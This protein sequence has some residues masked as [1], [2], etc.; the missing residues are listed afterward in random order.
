MILMMIIS[1]REYEDNLKVIEANDIEYDLA[2]L[3]SESERE[4]IE[5]RKK[6]RV[7]SIKD[8]TDIDITTAAEF[9]SS[10]LLLKNP[11][12]IAF[13]DSFEFLNKE[14]CHKRDKSFGSE[15]NRGISTS[16]S[17]NNSNNYSSSSSSSSSNNSND[18]SS[19]NK[20]VIK[21]CFRDICQFLC[22]Y[23]QSLSLRAIIVHILMLEKDS[24]KFHQSNCLS[25]LHYN[26]L[27]K[28]HEYIIDSY[29][30]DNCNRQDNACWEVF[31]LVLFNKPEFVQF[32]ER[33]SKKFEIALYKMP[34][35][36]CVTPFAFRKA[37]YRLSKLKENNPSASGYLLSGASSRGAN[38]AAVGSNYTIDED[39]IEIIENCG[40]LS[41]SEQ[42]IFDYDTDSNSDFSVEVDDDD[43]LDSD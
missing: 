43:D 20:L 9:D 32:L 34:K 35:D 26:I 42:N 38:L 22:T 16:I 10:Y 24:L 31:C 33:I 40:E 18:N 41:K 5:S 4:V 19:N 29:E 39:G 14:F 27:K 11:A 28:I 30:L 3:Q 13:F 15:R 17:N 23:K 21:S 37:T 1:K 36:G 7:V 6:Q 12:S 8:D 25:Y 2:V